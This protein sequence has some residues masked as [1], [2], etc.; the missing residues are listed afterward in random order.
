MVESDKVLFKDFQ[1]INELTTFIEKKN[2]FEAE[3]GCHDDLVMC[4][5]MYAWAVAQD[6]FV[7]M[8]DQNVREEL[9]EKDKRSLEEDMS[10]FGFIL[11][12]T[13]EEVIVEKEKG[14]V[15]NM[16]SD[17]N[18]DSRWDQYK[19]KVEDLGMEYGMPASN[20]EWN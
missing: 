20:W 11:D 8:T 13:D 16:A 10:P 18:E 14:L 6:Y 17:W 2:S 3:D 1:I 15:W 5:V 7:E 12:G 4:L 9:Y 19:E